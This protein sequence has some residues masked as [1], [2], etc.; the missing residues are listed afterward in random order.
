MS[1][2]TDNQ[3]TPETDALREKLRETIESDYFDA[4]IR[5]ASDV[6]ERW[7]T[8]LWKDAPAT[9][10]FIH[11]L[12]DALSSANANVDASPHQQNS[13]NTKTDHQPS[14]STE[15]NKTAGGD[16]ASRLVR[17]DL[18]R[19]DCVCCGEPE[20]TGRY[21]GLPVCFPCYETGLLREWLEQHNALDWPNAKSA[22]TD[23]SEKMI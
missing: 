19:A 20:Q 12:R 2:K 10:T 6:V 7:E 23:A 21:A 9:A 8:P 5:A 3:P 11:R 15:A 18:E 4:V 13:M 1:T 16:C 14:D 17:P 22:G